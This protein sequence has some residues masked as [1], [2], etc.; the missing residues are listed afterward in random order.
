M[1]IKINDYEESIPQPYDWQTGNGAKFVWFF[2]Y[3]CPTCE[4]E[5]FVL[6]SS[7]DTGPYNIAVFPEEA[8][9]DV[10]KYL[11]L[12]TCPV[13]GGKLSNS[14]KD[15]YF[16]TNDIYDRA[17]RQGLEQENE[18]LPFND[19][20]NHFIVSGKLT[21]SPSGRLFG[22][23]SQVIDCCFQA[24]AK[25]RRMLRSRH[26]NE[27][28]SNISSIWDVPAAS[29]RSSQTALDIKQTNESLRDYIL[30]LLNMETNIYS[31]KERLRSLYLER[32]NVEAKIKEEKT[33]KLEPVILQIEKLKSSPLKISENTVVKKS[34]PNK[35]PKPEYKEAGFFNK[36]KIE[37]EN[38]QIK[39]EYDARC[40]EYAEKK[41]Q[42]KK[43]VEA[44][45]AENERL[46]KE[47]EEAK[48]IAIKNAYSQIQKAGKQLFSDV[49]YYL[50]LQEMLQ[51][52]DGEIEQAENLLREYF[53]TRNE[54][55][56]YDI[57][58]GKYR[59]PVALATFY[60]YLMAGRC[61][62]LE[63]PNGAYNLYESEIRANMIISQLSTIISQLEEIKQNQYTIY[64]E[65]KGMSRSLNELASTMKQATKA[66]EGI[67][68]NTG[69]IA[70]YSEVIAN[71]SSVI[72]Y[73]TAKSAFYAKKNAELTNAMG[74][75]IALK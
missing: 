12:N 20:V 45:E 65:L 23:Y 13:C 72:A 30:L 25:Q 28:I 50:P 56:S 34:P 54:L 11:H 61:D 38:A 7:N 6:W 73:N 51:N 22:D 40:Q 33:D 68:R 37:A 67:E 29:K 42:Y 41:R 66:I 48:D 70:D 74:Y 31:L 46:K 32:S 2:G 43:S 58:F 27:R 55:Y 47:A 36:K 59:E 8:R 62:G 5:L 18:L 75:L 63:G 9:T 24:A 53:K 26:A 39:A 1:R 17:R 52:M 15:G 44:W 57:I 14:I 64:T 60:E 35:P 4:T 71:N 3:C 10:E 16:I 19:D 69:R 49:N 21:L